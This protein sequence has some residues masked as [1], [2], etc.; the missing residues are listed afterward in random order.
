MYEYDNK[1]KL[2]L[3]GESGVGKSC[4]VNAFYGQKYDESDITIGVNFK[5]KILDLDDRKIELDIWDT[6]GQERFRSII[7][8]YFRNVHGIILVF[9]LT[10]RAS[11][12]KL[13]KW[14]NEINFFMLDSNYK[15]I[16]VGNKSDEMFQQVNDN[17]INDFV[18]KYEL[19]YI[20]SSAKKNINIDEIFETITT[21]ILNSNINTTCKKEHIKLTIKQTDCCDLL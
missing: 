4:I 20:R 21:N 6:G 3:A 13:E 12:L 15:M 2:I 10:N 14:M 1:I 8:S 16:L 7:L 5:P 11:F 9:D 17:E 18:K 19:E